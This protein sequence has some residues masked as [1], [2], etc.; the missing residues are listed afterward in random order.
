MICMDWTEKKLILNESEGSEEFFG[1][2][3]IFQKD[4]NFKKIQR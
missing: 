3:I 1:T 4:V 2:L